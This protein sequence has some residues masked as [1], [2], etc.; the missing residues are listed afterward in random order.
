MKEGLYLQ[1][2]L[3][4]NILQKRSQAPW[5]HLLTPGV[6]WAS[7]ASLGLCRDNPH[8]PQCSWQVSR[9]SPCLQANRLPLHPLHAGLRCRSDSEDECG[10]QEADGQKISWQAAIFKVGDDCRQVVRGPGLPSFQ[11][12][13]CT[14]GSH[15]TSQPQ[16]LF[17]TL[18]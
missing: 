10:T 3:S 9:A 13:R 17:P 12:S 2:H 5:L 4:L 1:F 7:L 14:S 15:L 16:S 18:G 6:C 11:G 8:D